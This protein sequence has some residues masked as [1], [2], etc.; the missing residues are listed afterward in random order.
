M[1]LS[2]AEDFKKRSLGALPT[3]LEK[4]AYICSLQNAGGGYDH[5]GLNH[6]FGSRLAQ[7]AILRAHTETSMELIRVPLREL[8]EEYQ[9]AVG[10]SEGPQVLRGEDFVLKGPVTGDELLSAHLRL[11][12]HSVAAVAHQEHTNPPGA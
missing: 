8:Y 12:Q 6:T 4:L 10:R 2:A 9:Q 3:L 7:D 5:W 11:L 1:N